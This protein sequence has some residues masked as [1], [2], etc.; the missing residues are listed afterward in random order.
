MMNK[1][2][3]L[4]NKRSR[5]FT[6]VEVL[7]YI[8]LLSLFMIILVEIFV[9][10]L[11]LRLQSQS[12]SAIAQDSR[13]ILARLGYDIGNAQSVTVPGVLGQTTSSLQLT[14]GGVIYT[15]SLDVDGNLVIT[16]AGASN[17]LNSLDTKISGITFK[18]VGS[19]GGKPTIQVD[20]TIE[21]VIVE[22]S[23]TRSQ[24]IQTTYGLR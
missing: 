8:G 18:R 3:T 10:V 5:G 4:I 15:Y 22:Q 14:K 21:S 7:L 12:T 6:L 2:F 17:K 20:Y 9:S 23:G 16:T 19:S 24:Q 11:K 13:F 1:R